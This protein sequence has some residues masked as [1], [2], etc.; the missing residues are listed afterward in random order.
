[1]SF[2]Y[3]KQ[4][5]IL[6]KLQA[7]KFTA[8]TDLDNGDY[9]DVDMSSAVT[10]KYDP[11]ATNRTSGVLGQ[12]P[13]V[14][15]APSGEVKI[16]TPLMPS[17]G[18]GLPNI[19]PLL[20][21]SGFK[22]TTSTNEHVYDLSS[23]EDDWK[24]MTFWQYAGNKTTS[25][26]L[27]NKVHSTMFNL[28]VSGETGKDVK[29]E[30]DGV[31]AV[32]DAPSAGQSFVAGT[33]TRSE[34]APLMMFNLARI[35]LG[36]DTYQCVKFDVDLG[37]KVEQIK[38]DGTSTISGYAGGL[39]TD[40]AV[41]IKATVY[42]ESSNADSPINDLIAND[43]TGALSIEFGDTATFRKF[44]ID[45]SSCQIVNCVEAS[46][47]GLVMWDIEAIAIDNDLSI[48]IGNNV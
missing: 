1:M 15:G 32:I 21:A 5:V 46:N 18:V 9:L 6:G 44:A 42:L 29:F 28:K 16:V 33:L 30:F 45:S 37:N 13:T 47:N 38:G 23:I 43:V 24:H 39:I 25:S 20:K 14:Q 40:R 17:G 34:N 36:N 27:L 48:T 4:K 7:T 19:D 11:V 2:T 22:V 12:S 10:I 31:G 41:K 26:S 3:E 35:T 8:E